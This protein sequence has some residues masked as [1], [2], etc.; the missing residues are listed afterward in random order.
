MR[1][2]IRTAVSVRSGTRV[3]THD[4][5]TANVWQDHRAR[6]ASRG[7]RNRVGRVVD[8]ALSA[9]CAKGH[10]TICRRTREAIDSGDECDR[11]ACKRR[12]GSITDYVGEGDMAGSV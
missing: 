9:N 8:T 6:E 11:L 1:F 4:V 12:I 7:V 5:C 2:Q 3:L 10:S